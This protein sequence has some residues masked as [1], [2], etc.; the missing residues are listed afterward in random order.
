MTPAASVAPAIDPGREAAPMERLPG[1][2]LDG[3]LGLELARE[4]DQ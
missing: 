2:A 4:I 3:L 1:Q